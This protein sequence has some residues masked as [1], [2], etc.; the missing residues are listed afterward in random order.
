MRF[1]NAGHLM[2]ETCLNVVNFFIKL[3]FFKLRN[4]TNTETVSYL[5]PAKVTAHWHK[6][7]TYMVKFE[8]SVIARDKQLEDR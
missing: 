1:T 5:Q 2:L 3:S 7:T 4:V 6:G 8:D